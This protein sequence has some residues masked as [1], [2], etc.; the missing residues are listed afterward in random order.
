MI[1][2]PLQIPADEGKQGIGIEMRTHFDLAKC[3]GFPVVPVDD[4]F[5]GRHGFLLVNN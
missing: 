5:E 3:S 1:G 2:H 4:V